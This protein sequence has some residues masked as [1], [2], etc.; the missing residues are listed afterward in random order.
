M[1][2]LPELGSGLVCVAAYRLLGRFAD[3]TPSPASQHAHFMMRSR[4]LELES[5]CW[6][7]PPGRLGPI[8]KD[9]CHLSKHVQFLLALKYF[10]K[11]SDDQ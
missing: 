6:G 4:V 2:E 5:G 9:N 10:F 1:P 7:S 8:K 3:L 11:N